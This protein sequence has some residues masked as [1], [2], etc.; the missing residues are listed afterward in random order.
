MEVFNRMIPMFRMFTLLLA[1]ILLPL[2]A[3]AQSPHILMIGDSMLASHREKGASVG[4]ALAEILGEPG[5]QQIRQ[6]G[7]DHPRTSDNRRYGDAD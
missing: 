7:Q 2:S 5:A 3:F 6:R 1:T 4:D